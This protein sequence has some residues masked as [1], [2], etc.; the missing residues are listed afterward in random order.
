MG[1]A[2]VLREVACMVRGIGIDLQSYSEMDLPM[3]DPFMRKVFTEAERTEASKRDHRL[4]YLAGRFAAK[5]AA[6]KALGIDTDHVRLD[7]IETLDDACG[8]PHLSFS[9]S[10]ARIAA[11][12]GAVE[13]PL[14]SISHKDGMS[15]AMVLLQG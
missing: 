12:A 1:D 6:V 15:V 2:C 8:I 9:G 10:L 14:V 13:P 4:P 11:D 5:E 3:D 7:E